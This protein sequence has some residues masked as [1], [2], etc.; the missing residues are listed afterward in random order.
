MKKTLLYT[1]I[2][3][4]SFF[5]ASAQDFEWVKH[6]EGTDHGAHSLGLAVVTD[7]EGNIYSTGY[8][9]GTL[10]FDAGVGE[11]N[12]TT[13]GGGDAYIHKMD[14]DGNL[15]WVKQIVG[16]SRSLG[17]SIAVDHTGA[18]YVTG[19]FLGTVDFDPGAGVNNL[20]CST[21]HSDVFILKLD[22]DGDF[23]WVKQITGSHYDSGRQLKVDGAGNVYTIGF[24]YGGG[25]DFDPG[26][27]TS[28]LS[29][30]GGNDI[31]VQKLD[32]DGNFV[33]A[34]NMGGSDVDEGY[35]IDVDA[36]G[37]VYV[38]GFFV[39]EADFAPVLGEV[40]MYAYGREDA[41]VQ[42]LD[43][44][45]N[46]VWIR[47]LGGA[48]EEGGRGVAV[49]TSGNVYT[50]GYFVGTTDFKFGVGSV[51]L[52]AV[53]QV[54]IFVHKMDNDGTL[55]WV[56]QLGGNSNEYPHSIALDSTGNA[57][58]TGYFQETVDFD[59]NEDTTALTV[60]GERDVFICKMS[61]TGELFW[62]KNMGGTSRDESF[63]IALDG[64]GGIY[65][66]GYFQ[67]TVDFDPSD[68]GT[69]TKT[70]TGS[71]DIFI[72]KMQD[73]ATDV[74]GFDFKNTV[75]FKIYPNPASDMITIQSEQTFDRIEIVDLSGKVVLRT[76]DLNIKT[77][78]LT[79]GIYLVK[80]FSNGETCVK[81]IVIQ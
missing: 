17:R 45:G 44:A 22:T 64:T 40:G 47:G 11:S 80:V 68:L 6:F 37:N 32:T 25:V 81:K 7:H 21:D 53:G 62:A 74:G 58:I 46:H 48:L 63:S 8:F 60:E 76:N 28:T 13:T 51:E 70:A 79:K 56:K 71:R 1:T 38:T 59:P 36:D 78:E 19:Y 31:Y 39:G 54:D 43:A 3:C 16:T 26:P 57:Y 42:K 69:A 77:N 41:F 5:N 29:S 75:D 18:V 33:W 52:T 35:G 66:T 23:E 49:D 2:L 55:L 50:V 34:R 24:F 30:H 10:D 27:L 14:S 65:T 20:V 4:I 67:E 9:E 61:P 72:Q 12:L 73:N 15:I